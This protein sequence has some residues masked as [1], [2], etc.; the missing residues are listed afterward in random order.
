MFYGRAIYY[1]YR[2]F[3]RSRLMASLKKK[4]SLEHR[5][6]CKGRFKKYSRLVSFFYDRFE[7]LICTTTTAPCKQLWNW[8]TSKFSTLPC[9]YR[10][11]S[12]VYI[13]TFFSKL[14]NVWPSFNN[15]SLGW[16]ANVQFKISKQW[17]Y[18]QINSWLTMGLYNT[19]IWLK[20]NET[21]GLNLTNCFLKRVENH[22]LL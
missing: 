16:I 21:R 20:F 8:K 2:W 17:V 9:V 12:W 14:I 19:M 11:S 1:F 10:L 6:L 3:R 4:I 18:P 15:E 13:L 5:L 22:L 7:P